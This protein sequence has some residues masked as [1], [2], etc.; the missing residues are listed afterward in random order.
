MAVHTKITME[1]ATV[2][3]MEEISEALRIITVDLMDG[4]RLADK[5]TIVVIRIALG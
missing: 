2:V 5:V 1:A 4:E 3:V